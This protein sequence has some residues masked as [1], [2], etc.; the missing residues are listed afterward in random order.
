MGLNEPY[1]EWVPY[2]P[3]TTVQEYLTMNQNVPLGIRT[4]C[5]LE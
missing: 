3:K 5:M 4:Y 2:M 1:L